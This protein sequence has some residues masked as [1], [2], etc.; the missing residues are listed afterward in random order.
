MNELAF[1][2]KKFTY[3]Y[4]SLRNTWII[5]TSSAN[6]NEKFYRCTYSN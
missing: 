4:L 1:S 2:C 6:E 5:E 3:L